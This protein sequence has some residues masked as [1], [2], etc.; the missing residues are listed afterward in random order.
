MTSIRFKGTEVLE[1]QEGEGELLRSEVVSMAKAGQ[2]PG[3]V[4]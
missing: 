2:L 4:G 1:A 3:A